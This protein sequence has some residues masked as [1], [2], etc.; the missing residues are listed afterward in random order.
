MH[1]IFITRKIP[2]SGLQI[3]REAG[4]LADVWQK[5]KPPSK[6][7]IKK[8]I[9]KG[10][11]EGIIS[12]LTDVIDRNLLSSCPT[13]KIVANYAAGFNNID[14]TA[15]K[16]LGIA[17]AN[18]PNV[19][20]QAVAEHAVAL[21][22]AV[23]TR[24]AE[25]DR[26]VR[27]GK[28]EGFSPFAFIGTDLSGK[29][30]GLVG[31]GDIGSRTA[32]ILRYGFNANI[33]YYD[34]APHEGV[35]RESSAQRREKLDD[36]LRESDVVSLHVPL[37]DSTRHLIDVRAL[38]IMKPSAILVNTARGPVIDENALVTALRAGTIRG[39]GLDVFE[40]EPKLA[41][42]LAKLPNVVMTPHIASARESV[43]NAMSEISARN[44]VDFFAGKKP[45]GL[46]E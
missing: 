33:L 24:L 15:A 27:S 45:I 11:H 22:L 31:V 5:E 17:V 37:L 6:R 1:K 41:K 32:K 38:S 34:I 28:F 20:G 39:A 18:T 26:F 3:L 40:F 46:L 2:E 35:E 12:Q 14:L 30:V 16:E 21:I 29:T 13:V 42:G 43:R 8:I 25:G 36:L 19:S 23:S 4:I 9:E 44:I 7:Q 10:R